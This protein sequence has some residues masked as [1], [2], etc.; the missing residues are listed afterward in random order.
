MSASI[1]DYAVRVAFRAVHN[2]CIDTILSLSLL[3]IT[4]S[5]MIILLDGVHLANVI[6]GIYTFQ[7]LL[8]HAIR[9]AC[10]K[11]DIFCSHSISPT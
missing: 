3:C 1:F 2:F 11:G 9:Q 8:E 4:T 10:L 6:Y 5:L 7:E